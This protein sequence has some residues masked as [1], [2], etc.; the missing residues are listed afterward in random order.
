MPSLISDKQTNK[1]AEMTLNLEVGPWC[2]PC[3]QSCW[4]VSQVSNK[5]MGTICCQ[6]CA[7]F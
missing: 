6:P 2:V 3:T 7:A 5:S 4:L 1:K